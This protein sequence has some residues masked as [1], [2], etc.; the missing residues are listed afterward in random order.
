MN[1]KIEVLEEEDDEKDFL[2]EQ[3]LIVYQ[4]IPMLRSIPEISHSHLIFRIFDKD[5]N[6]IQNIVSEKIN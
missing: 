6:Q 2:N 3:Q 5:N 1:I 4:N